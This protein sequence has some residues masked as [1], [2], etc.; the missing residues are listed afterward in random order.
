MDFT[1][2]FNAA[3]FVIPLCLS[4][5]VRSGHRW[6]AILGLPAAGVEWVWAYHDNQFEHGGE[7]NPGLELALVTGFFALVFYLS[8]WLVGVLLGAGLR[9]LFERDRKHRPHPA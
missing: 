1:Y 8:P 4:L 7:W 2:A 9:R 6:I 5:V 3:Y